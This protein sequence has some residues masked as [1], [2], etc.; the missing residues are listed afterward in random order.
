MRQKSETR[1]GRARASRNSC[2][3]WFRDFNNPCSQTLQYSM[4]LLV[5]G[6]AGKMI[7]FR[8]GG[9]SHG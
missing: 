2:A 3:G 6:E 1:A 5:L 8:V 9:P 7:T 4:S